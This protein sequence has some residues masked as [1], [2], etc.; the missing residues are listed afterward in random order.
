MLALALL[1]STLSLAVTPVP[2]PTP[3]A[4]TVTAPTVAP[5][6]VLRP[7]FTVGEAKITGGTAFYVRLDGKTALVTA[8]QLLGPSLG[9]PAQVAAADVPKQVTAVALV[10]AYTGQ[11]AGVA[12]GGLLVADA[13]T[14]DKGASKDIAVFPVSISGFDTVASNTRVAPAPLEL[15]A[16]DPKVGDTVWLAAALNGDPGKAR[17]HAAK[18]GQVD[19][20]ALYVDFEEKVLDLAG[21]AGAPFLD[22]SGKV[23]GMCVGGGKMDDGV[24]V[25]AGNPVSSIR[26]RATKALGGK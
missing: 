10:D 8:H 26:L 4:A 13:D 12:G 9:L 3:A 1:L 7:T 24:T 5:G 18:V 19:G 15:A 21:T 16:A 25:G 11:V 22:A 14:V 23:V 6:A 2:A 17:L 20:T